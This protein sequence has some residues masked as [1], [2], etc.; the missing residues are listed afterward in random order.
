[1]LEL[2]PLVVLASKDLG[3]DVHARLG[4]QRLSR[5]PMYLVNRYSR[6]GSR[7]RGRRL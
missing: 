7:G 2:K 6:G 5:G 3:I 1:M 4:K